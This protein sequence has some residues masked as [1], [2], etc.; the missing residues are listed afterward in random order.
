MAAARAGDRRSAPGVRPGSPFVDRG[1][2]SSEL[3]GAFARTRDEGACHGGHR[4]RARRDRQVAARRG[5]GRRGRRRGHGRGRPLP[6]L[7]RGRDLPPARRDRRAA[8]RRRPA[9]ARRGAA[10]GRTSRSRELVLGAIGLSD[11]PAQAE[12]TYWAVRR[13]LE[14]V[15][16]RAAPASWSSR[17][18]TGPSRRC[19]TCSSTS[20]PSPAGTRSC[21]P[22]SRGRTSWRPARPGS[23]RSR[24]GRCWSSTRSRTRTRARLVESAGGEEL[25]R[26]RRRGSSTRPRATRSSSSSSWPSERTTAAS[27]LPSSIQAVLAARIDRLDP[28]ER[29]VLERPRSRAAA[30]TSA[31]LERA[32]PDERSGRS[33]GDAPGLARPAAADPLGPLGPPRPGRVPVR[34]RAD[35]RGRLPRTSQAAARRAARARWPRWLERGRARRTRRSATTS[36][37]PTAYSGRARPGRRARASA[38]DGAAE[39]L[40]SAA[41]ARR[42]CAAISHGGARLL[43]RAA[44]LIAPDDPARAGC[45]PSSAP[46]C[47]TPA[48]WRTPTRVLAEAIERAPAGTRASRHA[49]ASSSS[50]CGCR[51]GRAGR[52]DARRGRRVRA[53]RARGTTATS[54][55]C[56]GRVPAGRAL[57]IEGRVARADEA[58]RRAAEHARRAG[59][60]PALFEVL[61]WRAAAAVFGPTPVPEAIAPLPASSTSR[62]A[63]SPVA[64]ARGAPRA[65]GAARDGRRPRRGAP[66]RRRRRRD[67]RRARRPPLGGLAAGGARRDARRPAAGSR[68]AAARGLRAARARWARRRCS[69]RPRRCSRRRVYAQ[70]R[71]DEAARAL[72]GERGGRGG[73]RPLGPGRVEGRA[74]EAARGAGADGR[75]ARRWPRRRYGSPSRTDFLTIRADALLDLAE[76]LRQ[77]GNARTRPMRRLARGA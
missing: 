7:R 8:R 66:A 33:I 73:G 76:V 43:E 3:R 5:A 38:G 31:P 65:G 45:C 21:S 69:P 48:G 40:D 18:S 26:P 24:T 46:R 41:R 58:W 71:H 10:R 47:S 29:A 30:S 51:R 49:R 37:R 9:P 60:E 19:S 1:A 57:L 59:N 56:A 22:A 52:T 74:R 14:R 13:L 20:S 17:T 64:R 25:G 12:E 44:A 39:R 2:S 62:C 16:A 15:A 11:G 35:P 36:P 68:G 63:S 54:S 42:S 4:D 34:A 72:P 23:P 53:R 28:G 61:D 70:G 50:S 27:A 67:P 6:V 55:A 77:G 32:A 75:R